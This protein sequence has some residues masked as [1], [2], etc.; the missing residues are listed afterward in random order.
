MTLAERVNELLKL[1]A[2]VRPV[3]LRQRLRIEESAERIRFNVERSIGQ[4]DYDSLMLKLRAA[5]RSRSFASVSLRDMRL[6]ASCLFDGDPCLAAD[7][8]FLQLYLDGLRS[9][10][11]R[12]AVKRLIHSYCVHFD[13][14]LEAIRRIG[15][16]LH[17]NIGTIGGRWE[18]P[19]RHRRHKLFD[20]IQAPTAVAGVTLRSAD[21]RREL[22]I[23]GLRGQ[24]AASGLAAHVFLSALKS[25]EGALRRNPSSEVVDRA[26]SWVR[27]DHPPMHFWAHRGA[28][29]NA[30]LLPW[31][32]REPNGDI[33]HKIQ[34]FLLD[35]LNDPRI[36]GS[37][38][39]GISDAAREVIIRWIA[40]ATLEQFLKVVDRVAPKHQWDYRRAFWNAYIQ[41]GFVDNAWV[42]FATH[43]AQVAQQIANDAEDKLMR[44]FATLGGA[45]ADQAVLLLSIGDLVIADWSHNGRLRI[46]RRANAIAPKLSAKSYFAGE[47]RSASDF[48]AVHLPPDGWQA[49][50]E[51]YIRKHAG[52]RLAASE[53]MPHRKPG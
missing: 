45:A 1:R 27:T 23:V 17:E 34:T 41:K 4:I 32:D 22:E 49:R 6:A 43:G 11:S 10:R 2:V 28:F 16:F 24:L 14:G 46:W 18:W 48:D 25:I 19:E 33:R 15:A 31:A 9:I 39:L 29:A 51:G 42:A 8:V 21:P 35:N 44:R 52:I 20:P 3:P 36:D 30:L 37:G 50:T 40:Q 12:I 53:Y 5:A 7:L 13:P 38:W 26:I 47:L